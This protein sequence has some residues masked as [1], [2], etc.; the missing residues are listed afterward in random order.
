MR[1]PG[2][3]IA[4]Y[5]VWKSNM[6]RLGNNEQERTQLD[7]EPI[8][9][10][11]G[12]NALRFATLENQPGVP[13]I[14]DT[15]QG[16][17]RNLGRP[18]VFARLSDCNLTC[19]WCDT[20]QTW[21]FTEKRAAAHD[22]GEVYDTAVEQTYIE[23]GD[24]VR[25]ID[26]YPIKRLVITGGEPLMQQAGIVELVKGLREENEEYWVEIE[27]NGTI[28]PTDALVDAVDQFNVSAKLANSGNVEKKRR[29]SKALE[30]FAGLE[31][32]DFKFVVFG[33]DDLPE[34]LQLV[35]DYEIPHERV[36]LMPGG[37]SEEEV[38]THQEQ[39]V[40]LA[41]KENFNITTRLHVLIWGSKRNV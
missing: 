11:M 20:P 12:R 17:G 9:R 4:E 32:A 5:Y 26:N 1:V 24:A 14:F 30:K 37:R 33:E 19:S 41:K 35:E 29:K 7:I 25:N 34:I 8:R 22:Q 10:G 23:I 38:K 6:E 27:T 39:L 40:E 3:S 31:K 15:I 16:E 13:E 21:A 36:F 18:V 2:Q 28:P